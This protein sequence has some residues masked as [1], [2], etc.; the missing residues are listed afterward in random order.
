MQVKI[1]VLLL[2]LLIVGVSVNAL[3]SRHSQETQAEAEMLEKVRILNQEMQAVWQFIEINQ[4]RIDTDANGEYNFKNIYCAIAGKSVAALFM[5]K[6]DY[7][8]RYISEQPRARSGWPDDFELEAYANFRSIGAMDGSGAEYYGTTQI[9]GA[10]VFRYVSPLYIKQSCLECH[11]SPAGEIDITGFAKEGLSVG[12]MAG[13]VSIIMPIDMYMKGIQANI[14]SQSTMFF[15]I[16]GAAIIIVF[17]A[18]SILVNRLVKANHLLEEQGKALQSANQT[19][20][21]E[22]E[23]KSEFFATMSHELR[24]PLTSILAF[25][26]ICERSEDIKQPSNR[27][28][29]RE[30]KDSGYLLLSMVNDILEVARIDAG[31][32]E[33]VREYIDMVDLIGTVEGSI[34]PLAQKREIALLTRVDSDVPLIYADWEKI[35][36]IVENLTNNAVKF[37]HHSGAVEIAVSYDC[38]ASEVLISVRDTG[39]GIPNDQLERIFERYV[40][41]DKS[42]RKRYSGTGLGLAV[43]KE[44]A[45]AHKG[46]V[47]VISE[48]KQGSTFTVYIPTGDNSLSDE[49]AQ[50]VNN[51]G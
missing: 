44:F 35:R 11:G 8:I 40:Q 1:A 47:T 25:A 9:D 17:L 4:K 7:E 19:L 10:Q 14:I 36:R 30:I 51:V 46:R 33:L 34:R 18:V 5:A 13:A 22:Y 27:D 37:T 49:E 21:T 43:V 50:H 20:K 24:T 38:E 28:A 45:E 16:I 31:R 6:N 29:L 39:I 12:D 23:Y 26:E 3:W 32:V 15:L 42:A 41:L 2:V 48:H